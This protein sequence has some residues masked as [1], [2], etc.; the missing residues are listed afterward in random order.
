MGGSANVA[1]RYSNTPPSIIFKKLCM[2]GGF[3]VSAMIQSG[4]DIFLDNKTSFTVDSF[5][6]I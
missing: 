2:K 1:N 3:G 4:K 6:P 5:T